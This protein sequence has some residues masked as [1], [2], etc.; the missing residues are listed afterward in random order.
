MVF[1][2]CYIYTIKNVNNKNRNLLRSVKNLEKSVTKDVENFKCLLCQN[3][4]QMADAVWKLQAQLLDA[5]AYF[6]SSNSHR[7]YI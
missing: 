2:Y 1:I 5:P 3:V 6:C 7:P 4:K